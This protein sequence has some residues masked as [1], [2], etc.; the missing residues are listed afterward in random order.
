M[1]N[2][3][4]SITLSVRRFLAAVRQN[5][6]VEKAYLYGSHTS[7]QATRWSDIDLAVISSDFSNDLF[8][9]RVELLRLAADID[10]RIEPHPFTPE[11]FN[12]SDPL[13]NEIRKSGVEVS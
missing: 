10:D 1:V 2:V 9:E 8:D 7:G 5:K 4:D 13:A 12:S 6:R 3:Q 11:S